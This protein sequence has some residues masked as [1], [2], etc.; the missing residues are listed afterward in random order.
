MPENVDSSQAGARPDMVMDEYTGRSF[1]LEKEKTVDTVFAI[2]SVIYLISAL[3]FFLWLLF[4]I[5]AGRLAICQV[6]GC[7]EQQITKLRDSR[8]FR[9]LAYTFIGGGLGGVIGG[10]I[11]F[12]FWHCE[13]RAFGWRF[14]WKYITFPWLGATLAV[15]VYAIM[16]SGVAVFGGSVASGDATPSFTQSLFSLAVGALVGYGSP[17]VMKWLDAQVDKLFKVEPAKGRE[18]TAAAA[19][20]EAERAIDGCDVEVAASQITTDEQLPAAEG[21]VA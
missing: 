13:R 3:V 20:A 15:V 18:Q 14:I 2:V 21:G 16:A 10:Y 8:V 12:S 7:G 11:S 6:L 17:R 19:A 1:L 9:V 5:W 4:D